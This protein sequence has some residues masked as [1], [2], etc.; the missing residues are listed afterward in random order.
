MPGQKSFT[1]ITGASSGI[2]ECL[3]GELAKRKHNLLLV[4]RSADKLAKMSAE[5]SRAQG[6]EC[7][8]LAVDLAVAGAEQQVV[9]FTTGGGLEV[10]WLINNAG[11]GTYGKFCDLSLARELEMIRLNVNSLVALTHHY[12]A[13]MLERKRGV[14]LN[15]ASTAAF[16]PV[17]YLTTYAATKAFVLSFTEALATECEGTGVFVTC[18]CP[19]TTATRFQEVAGMQDR[20]HQGPS[21]TA[22]QVVATALRAIENRQVVAISGRMNRIMVHSQRLAPR[23][24]VVRAAARVMRPRPG[25]PLRAPIIRE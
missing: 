25:P 12:L 8:H 9:A 2:G 14:I 1:L 4:A 24:V 11:F 5:L 15:V 10:D 17:P 23:S 16:Q 13:P 18:L 20:V 21:E 22:E 7:R 6:I 3:A 19:G